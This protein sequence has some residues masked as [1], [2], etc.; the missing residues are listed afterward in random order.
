MVKIK[1]DD[2]KIGDEIKLTS[3]DGQEFN[4]NVDS[5]Q[6]EH[7]KI[8]IAKAGDEFGLKVDKP[9]KPKTELVKIS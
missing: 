3:A 7:S 8:E 2:L 6:I 1:K 4:Q 9:V 5:M